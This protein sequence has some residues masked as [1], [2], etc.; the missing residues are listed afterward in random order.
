M[1]GHRVPLPHLPGRPGDPAQSPDAAVRALVTAL[2]TI[3]D[4]VPQARPRPHFRAELRA[5]LVAVTPRIVAEAREEAAAAPSRRPVGQHSVGQRRRAHLRLAAGVR[6]AVGALAVC[7]LLLGGAVWLSR[8]ALP[9]DTLY[10]LKRAGESAQLALASDTGERAA[11]LLSFAKTRAD[12]VAQLLGRP[13]ASGTGP[14]AGGAIGPATAALVRSTLAS[15]DG[16]L[17][18]ASQLLGNQAVQ[19]RSGAPLDA[20]LQWAPGQQRRL[21][22]IAN[23]IPAGDLHRTAQDSADLVA[24][25]VARASALQA[26]AGCSCVGGAGSDALGPLPCGPCGSGSSHPT[27][28]PPTQAPGPGAKTAPSPATTPDSA[29]TTAPGGNPPVPPGPGTTLLPLPGGTRSG[30]L[31]IPLPP[32]PTITVVPPLVSPSTSCTPALQIGPIS[33]GCDGSVT[34]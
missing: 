31:P 25:A 26:D 6:I 33:V 17:R 32:P 4:A 18:Q 20:L 13:S 16:D 30:L 34:I 10:G 24:A 28:S 15:A 21:D 7:A 9:G 8:S 11:E 23:R 29:A 3:P 27:Q 12:E 1:T 19:T 5:Q 14:Q 2:A 22:D